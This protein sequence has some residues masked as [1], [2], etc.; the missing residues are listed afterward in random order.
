MKGSGKWINARVTWMPYL[1]DLPA[2]PPLRLGKLH[3]RSNRSMGLILSVSCET[4][5]EITEREIKAK[6]TCD[7]VRGIE[8]CTQNCL[9]I[10]K[11]KRLQFFQLQSAGSV[12]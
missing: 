8:A 1:G 2:A 4:L 3:I 7:T 6:L 10:G 9:R 11:D 12:D 5:R